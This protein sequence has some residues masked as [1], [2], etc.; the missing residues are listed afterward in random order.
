MKVSMYQVVLFLFA[1]SL[2]GFWSCE[3]MPIS[4]DAIIAAAEG[5]W[6]KA[7]KKAS[8]DAVDYVFK[9][10][11]Y[12]EAIELAYREK[13][14]SYP[15]YERRLQNLNELYNLKNSGAISRQDFHW[16]ASGLSTVGDMNYFDKIRRKHGY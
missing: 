4:P 3:S 5:D 1:L 11:V 12:T 15:E 10:E 16:K 13:A 8:N 9:K 6:E 14:I 7:A 2:L